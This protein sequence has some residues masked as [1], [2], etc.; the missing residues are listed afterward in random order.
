MR[1]TPFTP[2]PPRRFSES[3]IIQLVIAIGLLLILLVLVVGVIYLKTQRIEIQPE[4]YMV[5]SGVVGTIGGYLGAQVKH[6]SQSE[7]GSS[8]GANV[9]T[10]HV[11]TINVETPARNPGEGEG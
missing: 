11:G 1:R 9:S 8:S 7:Q 10:D 4:L 2:L 6:P 5:M 3:G